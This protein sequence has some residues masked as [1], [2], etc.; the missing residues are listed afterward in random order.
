MKW[1]LGLLNTADI[2]VKVKI[3]EK[4]EEYVAEN[5]KRLSFYRYFP[6]APVSI[7]TSSSCATSSPTQL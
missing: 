4:W 6:F 5:S 2:T 7:D 3:L 1:I